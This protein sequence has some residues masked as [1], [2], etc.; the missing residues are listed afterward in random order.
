[1]HSYYLWLYADESGYCKNYHGYFPRNDVC[2][3]SSGENMLV[4]HERYNLGKHPSR[5]RS[6]IFN[7]G[8]LLIQLVLCLMLLF[9]IS[10]KYFISPGITGQLPGF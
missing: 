5:Y 6:R 4:P 7:I 10:R 8:F 9:Y 3:L 1:M 2:V